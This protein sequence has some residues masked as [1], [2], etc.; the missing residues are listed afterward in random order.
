[1]KS[2]WI[3]IKNLIFE[4]GKAFLEAKYKEGL[5]LKRKGNLFY[6]FE[7]TLP[8]DV[9]YEIDL[10]DKQAYIY[11]LEGWDLVAEKKILYQRSSKSY[12]ISSTHNARLLVDDD[13]RLGYYEYY[14]QFFLALSSCT[15]FPFLL[16]FF[17]LM[18]SV[19]VTSIISHISLFLLIPFIY[20]I[21]SNM[22]CEHSICE[23]SKKRGILTGFEANYI[24]TFKNL[25]TNQK[26][27]MTKNLSTFGYVKKVSE[28]IFRLQSPLKKEE[29]FEEIVTLVQI[30]KHNV[31]L[32]NIGELYMLV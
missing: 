15:I 4:N 11:Q 28:N 19:A 9:I 18:G 2:V 29:L 27:N 22:A 24:L 1:M 5:K 13:L 25:T 14:Q 10:V 21:R 30:N 8:R 17:L 16:T 3:P 23:M 6:T 32:M 12:Y 31:N 26:E 7:E 20:F